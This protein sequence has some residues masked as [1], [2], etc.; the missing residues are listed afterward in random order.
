MMLD[1]IV[2]VFCEVDDFCQAFLPQ[3]EAF[4]IGPGGPAPRGPHV[5]QR[6]HH[7]AACT[8]QFGFQVS[9]ELLSRLRRAAGYFPGMPCY[10]HFVA[11]QKSA[12]VALVVFLL[13][14][15]GTRTGLYYIDSTA[16][17]V[18]DNHRIN[19]HKVFAGLAQRGKTS[20]GWFFGFKLHLVFNN[21]HEIVA[22]KLTPGNVHDTT[23]VPALTRDLIGKLF[24]D[25]GYIGQKLAEDLLRRG[26][27]LFTRIRKNMKALPIS[28]EDKA[29]L[30]A[31]NMA[32]TII[33]H[34]KEFSSL[35]L[36]KHR[37]AINAFVHII[38]AIT[39]YQINP[40]KP[41]LNLQPC[42]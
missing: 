33:G 40:F 37:S 30:N 14:H 16:L 1:R 42:Y 39:A 22:L 24:G 29:L 18:C 6:D 36:S 3:W 10:E 15:L 26:L 25:K 17:P 20:M 11:L 27:T 8:P 23:P 38:A 4:L 19:R 28:L 5:D 13:S 9:Q 35:N 41:K 7:A 21:D 2:E 34:I 31:R 12:F 32:E